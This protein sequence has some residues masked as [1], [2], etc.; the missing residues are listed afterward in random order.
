MKKL[1]V[2]ILAVSLAGATSA[3]ASFGPLSGATF[4]GSGIPNDAVEV[5]T[6]TDGGNT[7]TLG[8]T[9]TPRYQVG[10]LANNNNGT[11]Y[12]PAGN[13]WNFDYYVNVTGS[14]NI[15][16]YTFVLGYALVPG[17]PTASLGS[18]NLSA[19]Y[20]AQSPT[21]PIQDSQWPGFGYLT[22]GVAGV[23]TPPSGAYA[24]PY[25]INAGGDYQFV[26]DAYSGSTLIG[27]SGITVDVVPEPTTMV[28]GALLLL[29]FGASTLRILRKRQTA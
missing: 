18:F 21:I 26:L 6:I 27:Q 5:T 23:V 17:T 7:I 13:Q 24:G 28:A 8:L 25:N 19:A 22:T 9:A 2:A 10:E 11:F 20:S 4:G 16:D 1:Q 14:G 12:A 15:S 3:S 29:P